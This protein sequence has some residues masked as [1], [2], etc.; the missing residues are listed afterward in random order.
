MSLRGFINAFDRWRSSRR[1]CDPSAQNRA[2][3]LLS[4]L[5]KKFHVIFIMPT[6]HKETLIKH[7]KDC[8]N[9]SH[10]KTMSR[11]VTA[12]F[13]DRLKTPDDIKRV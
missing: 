9:L 10:L 2:A 6:V 12:S 13:S 4:W 7:K 11:R 8:D 1:N 3:E 5:S